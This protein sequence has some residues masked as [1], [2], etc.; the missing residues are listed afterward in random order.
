LDYEEGYVVLEFCSGGNARELFSE[1]TQ[2][3]EYQVL[4]YLHQLSNAL[5]VITKKPHNL[6]ISSS[7]I[8][9]SSKEKDSFVKLVYFKNHHELQ[10]I[11]FESMENNPN[12]FSE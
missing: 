6:S 10:S 7:N 11:L 8:L 4:H 3:K 2:L 5:D 12:P 1:K 9:F